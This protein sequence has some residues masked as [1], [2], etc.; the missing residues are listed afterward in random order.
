MIMHSE[1]RTFRAVSL[2]CALLSQK[3]FFSVKIRT[4]IALFLALFFF[5]FIFHLGIS[6]LNLNISPIS[7]SKYEWTNQCSGVGQAQC[8]VVIRL[9]FERVSICRYTT[10]GSSWYHQCS[11]VEWARHCERWGIMFSERPSGSKLITVC[12][13]CKDRKEITREGF[14]SIASPSLLVDCL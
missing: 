1:Q 3:K 14:S 6:I 7:Q 12:R 13:V 8:S 11:L 9:P 2:V 4:H 10:S 5:Y